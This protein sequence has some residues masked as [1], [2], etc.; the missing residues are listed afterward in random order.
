MSSSW[1][2]RSRY[3]L[4]EF[5]GAFLLTLVYTGGVE[6]YNRGM[7][8]NYTN[9][10]KVAEIT[11]DPASTES[12]E[13]LAARVEVYLSPQLTG[14]AYAIIVL[15]GAFFV[16][17]GVSR[18]FNYPAQLTAHVAAVVTAV[19][20]RAAVAST[21]RSRRSGV[22]FA[23]FGRFLL[24]LIVYAAADLGAAGIVFA[25]N[26]SAVQYSSVVVG[27]ESATLSWRASVLEGTGA[28]VLLLA[29]YVAVVSV[30]TLR[31]GA[32]AAVTYAVYALQVSGA[33]A[34]WLA[35]A[36][37]NTHGTLDPVREGVACMYAAVSTNVGETYE[38]SAINSGAAKGTLYLYVLLP[39]HVFL[40][41]VAYVVAYNAAPAPGDAD[42]VTPP[43][44]SQPGD[45]TPPVELVNDEAEYRRR[46][47]N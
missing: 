29:T 43:L 22:A 19:E 42:D 35:I 38:C 24:T 40:A 23:Y 20:A 12:A 17:Y 32:D 5:V 3:I 45:D 2:S 41:I 36:W 21:K 8:D 46:K 7:S 15:V 44:S 16:R 26:N 18:A 11:A 9:M 47:R 34:V 1:A 27:S 31:A 28:L 13:D 14:F 25:L 30:A 37:T 39:M 33:A 6:L 10:V 4:A